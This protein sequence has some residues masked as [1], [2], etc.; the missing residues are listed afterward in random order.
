MES[1]W[2]APCIHVNRIDHGRV[3]RTRKIPDIA[4]SSTVI[5]MMINDAAT[6]DRYRDVIITAVVDVLL[7]LLLRF[8]I[9][10]DSHLNYN[11]LLEEVQFLILKVLSIII[12]EDPS[13]QL[14][15][16]SKRRKMS[17]V[18]NWQPCIFPESPAT[19]GV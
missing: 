12:R 13:V 10:F 17:I 7:L 18:D 19:V 3:T 6:A 9:N 15:I 14:I 4:V 11:L 2:S 5:S 8:M 1:R 16:C